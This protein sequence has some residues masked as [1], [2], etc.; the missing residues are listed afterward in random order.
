MKQK[1]FFI[2]FKGLLSKQVKPTFLEGEE[3]ILKSALD[4]AEIVNVV[5]L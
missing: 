2:I 3:M 4:T 1:T 5:G